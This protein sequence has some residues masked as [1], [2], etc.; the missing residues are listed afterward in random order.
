MKVIKICSREK[1]PC[2]KSIKYCSLP[3]SEKK[4]VRKSKK[5]PWKLLTTREK[6]EK[7]ERESDFHFREKRRKKSKNCLRVDFWLTQG[8]KTQITAIYFE[9][10]EK[11]NS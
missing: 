6:G 1:K 5:Y 10:I 7:S 2:V 4:T 3:S 9:E 11:Y 8:E